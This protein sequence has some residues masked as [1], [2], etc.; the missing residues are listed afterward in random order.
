MNSAETKREP[1]PFEEALARLE[2]L[3]AE[4]ESGKLGLDD[5]M[6]RFA[7]GMALAENCT[8]KLNDAEKKIEI[9]LKKNSDGEPRWREFLPEEPAPPRGTAG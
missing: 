1:I 9:L 8:R 5:T 7:E 2:K 4:M 3:V 6:Q